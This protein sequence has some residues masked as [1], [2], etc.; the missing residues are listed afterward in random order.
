[1]LTQRGEKLGDYANFKITE[2]KQETFPGLLL[3]KVSFYSL[4]LDLNANGVSLECKV[5]ICGGKSTALFLVLLT[6]NVHCQGT[7]SHPV[8]AD[9]A[10]DRCEAVFFT[11]PAGSWCKLI[12]TTLPRAIH[13]QHLHLQTVSGNSFEL[14]SVQCLLIADLLSPHSLTTYNRR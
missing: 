9:C 6:P 3:L 2:V 12:A 7:V 4:S 10:A 14:A 8:L 11:P 5:R 1:M 13:R